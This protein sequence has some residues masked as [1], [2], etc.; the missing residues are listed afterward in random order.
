MKHLSILALCLAMVHSCAG[1]TKPG[2]TTA[3]V[4]PAPTPKLV[5]T[6]GTGQFANIFCSLKDKKGRLWFGTM[7]EGVYR[8]DGKGFTQFTTSNG[9]C[10]N[11][12]Y[13]MLED[14]SGNIWFGTGY[15][16]CKYN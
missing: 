5:K 15:G 11:R 1:Q 12:V 16:V 6:Q 8:Y 13:S 10:N 7:G 3:A 9:L 14:R 2:I 4:S